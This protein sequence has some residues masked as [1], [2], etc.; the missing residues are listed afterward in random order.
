MTFENLPN[1]PLESVVAPALD[2]DTWLLGGT[3]LGME[4]EPS[5]GEGAGDD[6]RS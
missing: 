6:D 5:I 2:Q 3:A 4:L 1:M